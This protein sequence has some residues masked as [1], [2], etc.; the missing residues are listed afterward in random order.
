MATAAEA[1]PDFRSSANIRLSLSVNG[2]S[3]F[4]ASS[5]GTGYLSAHLNMH[6]RPKEGDRSRKIRVE[7]IETAETETVSLKWPTVDLD[8]GD[9]VELRILPEG[10]GDAPSDI[11]RSTDLPSNLFSNPDLAKELLQMV[12]DFEARIMQLVSKSE[13]GAC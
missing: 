1:D 8:V 10:E 11:R 3:R 13:N 7:G 6:D 2:T 9:V 12:S 4:I 5:P